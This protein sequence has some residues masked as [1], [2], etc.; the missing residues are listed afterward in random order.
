MTSQKASRRSASRPETRAPERSC[1]GS[2]WLMFDA[3]GDLF[4]YQCHGIG[5]PPRGL[6]IREARMAVDANGVAF[7]PERTDQ[8]GIRVL[9]RP[10]YRAS[11]SRRQSGLSDARRGAN[12]AGNSERSP[13]P[14]LV[15][16][17]HA[18]VDRPRS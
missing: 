11:S 15:G 8:A 1:G 14:V 18:A 12:A 13:V 9:S 16:A 10:K 2:A 4:K 17:S 5:G 7:A 6:P 3:G